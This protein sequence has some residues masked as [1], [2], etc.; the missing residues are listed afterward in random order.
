MRLYW[1]KREEDYALSK[2]WSS[3]PEDWRRS[4][5][6]VEKVACARDSFVTAILCADIF[7][8]F[9]FSLVAI[10]ARGARPLFSLRARATRRRS[11]RTLRHGHH[12]SHLSVHPSVRSSSEHKCPQEETISWCSAWTTWPSESGRPTG[13]Y[14]IL[15]NSL[16]RIHCWRSLQRARSSSKLPGYLLQKKRE[17]VTIADKYTVCLSTFVATSKHVLLESTPC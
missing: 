1:K 13:P 12:D 2:L 9:S 15:Y 3:A 5:I 6:I 14:P 16:R 7:F 8:F 11:V 4:I 10:V 17:P